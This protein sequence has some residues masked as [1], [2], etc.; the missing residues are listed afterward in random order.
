MLQMTSLIFHAFAAA[1]QETQAAA[2]PS[3]QP[4]FLEMALPFGL[5]IIIFYFLLIRPQISKQKEHQKLISELKKGQSVLTSGGLL[6][7]IDGLTDR[8]ITL[9]ISAGVKVKV[10]R[11]SVSGYLEPTAKNS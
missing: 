8:F 3:A 4:S 6:G 7:T 1:A 9:E 11:S 5:M 10:L 2:A